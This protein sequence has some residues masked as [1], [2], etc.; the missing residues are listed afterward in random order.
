MHRAYQPITPANNKLLKKKWDEL[1]FDTH[2]QKVI[3]AQPIIDNQPPETYLHLH[4]KAKKKQ[5]EEERMAIVER[6][7]RL[8]VENMAHVMKGKPSFETT[9]KTHTKGSLNRTRRQRDLL[10][11]THENQAI[12]KRIQSKEPEYNHL[13]WLDQWHVNESY[14]ANISKYPQW[15]QMEE[16]E[17]TGKSETTK[18]IKETYDT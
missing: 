12:L 9:S 17:Y 1:R 3:S 15:E 18:T 10:R 11:V 4:M 7:N 8:L 2:R 16:T 13:Q 5:M 14:M 6:D